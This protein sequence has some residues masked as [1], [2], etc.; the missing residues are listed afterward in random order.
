MTSSNQPYPDIRTAI[1]TASASFPELPATATN[2][3]GSRYTSLNDLLTV[4][5]PILND[6]LLLL[7]YDTRLD[8]TTLT[9]LQH[10]HLVGTSEQMTSEIQFTVFDGNHQEVARLLTSARRYL[11]AA[12]FSLALGIT[13]DGNRDN[14]GSAGSTHASPPVSPPPTHRSGA[15]S[16]PVRPTP[17]GQET[18]GPVTAPDDRAG[19]H[20]NDQRGF[21]MWNLWGRLKISIGKSAAERFLCLTLGKSSM[22]A[23]TPDEFDLVI[24]ALEQQLSLVAHDDHVA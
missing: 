17:T 13:D 16:A 3:Y 15:H 23:V 22:K 8:N 18:L 5:K 6:N 2:F 1:F 9:V 21:L 11:M 12:T 20:A 14:S 4:A 7:T 10:I 19:V 24:S